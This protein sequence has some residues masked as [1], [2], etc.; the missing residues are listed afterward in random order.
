LEAVT[1]SGDSELKKT[2]ANDRRGKA[3][4]GDFVSEFT[5]FAGDES[6]ED[7][8]SEDTDDEGNKGIRRSERR[9]MKRMMMMIE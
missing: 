3:G 2:S 4:G 7:D 8:I 9:R 1:G 6:E 5:D